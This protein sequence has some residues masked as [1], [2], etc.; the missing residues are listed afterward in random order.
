MLSYTPITPSIDIYKPSPMNSDS[1]F[2]S[3]LP[4]A[5]DAFNIPF[6]KRYQSFEA[7]ET[8]DKS[9]PNRGD[10]GISRSKS[11]TSQIS[12]A[13]TD[14]NSHHAELP[15]A[16]WAAWLL[17]SHLSSLITLYLERQSN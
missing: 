11:G 10:K 17:I 3:S 12:L 13:A 9:Y 15:P 1:I 6:P 4:T 2:P 8:N 5:A 14:I 16:L 7:E